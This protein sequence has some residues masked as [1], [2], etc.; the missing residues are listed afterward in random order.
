MRAR[1]AAD[2]RRPALS[3]AAAVGGHLHHRRQP[4]HQRRRHRR[5]G[6]RHRALARA[7]PRSGAGRR[8]RAQQPQQA[9]EG[10][11]RL[12]PARICSSAPKARSASSPRRCCASCRG[13]RR[14]KPPGRRS[15][16][17]RP[18]SICWGLRPSAPP[19]ASP[20]SRS[21]R[22]RASTSCIKHSP[23][24]AIRSPTRSPYSVL[25]EL[26]SQ[27]ARGPARSDGANPRRGAGEGPGARRHHLRERRAGQGVLAHP[28]TVRRDAGPRG[29]LDQARRLGAGRQHPGLHRGGERRGARSSSPARGR[30]RSATSATATSTTTSPS[31]SAPTRPSTSSAGT[32]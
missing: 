2:E 8:P 20:A 30:C 31:R 22:A 25:I 15:R 4:L 18:R 24:R 23:A 21:C 7:R 16:R 27:R 26:S 19:A 11:H 9:Q 3:A 1:E 14:S 28:R 17:C 13:R 5:A 12:R 29:R 32:T 6:L 10:Q